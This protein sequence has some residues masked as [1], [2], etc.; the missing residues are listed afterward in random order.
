M[1]NI[2]IDKDALLEYSN[3]KYRT[4]NLNMNKINWNRIT[5]EFKYDQ[6]LFYLMC[7]SKEVSE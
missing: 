6:L 3:K 4:R 5:K 1:Q 2:R 7:S